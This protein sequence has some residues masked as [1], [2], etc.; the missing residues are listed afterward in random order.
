MSA[1]VHHINF[2]VHDL[3]RAVSVWEKLLDMPVAARDRL[4]QR[5]VITARFRLGA[6]WLVLVQPTRTD[7][8]PGR[9]LAEHGEGFFLLS[10]GSEDLEAEVRRLGEDWF[11]GPVRTGLDGWQVRDLDP[12]RTFGALLQLTCEHGSDGDPASA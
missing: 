8:V 10:L 6:M 5:G 7:S 4:E 11:A 9:F 1:A 3:D 12:R 2:V